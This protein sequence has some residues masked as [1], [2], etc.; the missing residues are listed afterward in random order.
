MAAEITL[1]L[2]KRFPSNGFTDPI[3]YYRRPLTGWLFR[4]RINL[5]LRMLRDLRFERALEV[6]YGSGAV[7]VPLHG[8]AAEVHGIDLDADPTLATS[9]LDALALRSQ[10]RQGSV[11]ELPYPD[12]HFDLVASFSTFE[13][14]HDFDKALSEVRRV[15]RPGGRF[16]LGMP[17]VN[18]MMEV[19]FL[20]IG[21]KGIDDHHV[22]TP[23]QVADR[24]AAHGFVVDDHARLTLP[25]PNIPGA[26]VY[27]DWLLRRAP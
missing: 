20:A 12:G 21:F 11:Y 8:V 15:L 27:Y 4:E 16:L 18:R 3:R 6:G 17:A 7:Q 1:D 14:L 23:Q 19:S 13:H 9:V 26:T 25:I 24:F 10:L 2:V 22:T 5:G